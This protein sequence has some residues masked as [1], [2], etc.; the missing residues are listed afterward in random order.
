MEKYKAITVK[1]LVDLV[2][3]YPKDFPK[4]L[5]TVIMSGDFE[6]NYLHE[7]HEIFIDKFKKYGAVICLGYEM[8]EDFE[9]NHNDD[10]E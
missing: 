3:E 6:G 10:E 1:D 2:T 8:H 7:K 9:E 5:N 4:G